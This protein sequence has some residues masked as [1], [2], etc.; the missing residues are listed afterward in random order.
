MQRQQDQRLQRALDQVKQATD[1]MR[2]AQSAASQGK[3]G[4]A[5]SEANARR[6]AERL[7]EAQDAMN[8]MRQQQA[9]SQLGDL[10]NRADQLAA[11]QRDFANRLRKAFGEQLL[12]DG[13]QRP[14]QQNPQSRQQ[15]KELADEKD[16]MAADVEQLEKDMQKAARDMAGT[17]PAASGRIREGLAEMQQNEAKLRMQYSARWIRQGQGGYMVPREAPITETMDKVADDLRAAQA[18]INKDGQ[19]PGGN[20]DAQRSLAQ[21]ERLRSQME[22][23]AGRGQQGGQQGPNGQQGQQGQQAGQGQGNGQQQGGQQGNGAGAGPNGGGQNGNINN[24][25]YGGGPYGNRFDGPNTQYGRFAPEGMYRIPDTAPWDPNRAVQE[26]GRALND[27]RQQYKDNPDVSRQISDVEREISR[28]QVGDISSQELQNRLN[29]VALPN[30]EALEL[31]LRREAEKSDGD[32][33]RSGSTDRVPA[34]YVDAVAE[35]FR[36]LSKGK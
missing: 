3:D 24:P 36:K 21:I 28:L 23:A 14:G 7:K 9:S 18:A 8:G 12:N 17:Q 26:A 30:L 33:V 10:S 27:L 22:R 20:S 19:Q 35:Y 16:K 32:Q 25:G 29:R 13:G 2:S 31:Q 6:A 4:A 5:N 11:Q 1:D 34:G 15:S